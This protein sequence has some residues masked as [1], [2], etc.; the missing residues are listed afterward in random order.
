[1]KGS[2][3]D[4]I[5]NNV[6]S[7]TPREWGSV[8]VRTE[9]GTRDFPSIRHKSYHF[10][11]LAQCH[12]QYMATL[13]CLYGYANTRAKC[14]NIS[15]KQDA[16]ISVY[17]SFQSALHVSGVDYVHLQEHPTV[18]TASGMIHRR[19][20]RPVTGVRLIFSQALFMSSPTFKFSKTE[21]LFEILM[22]KC[23]LTSSSL[24]FLRLY[25]STLNFSAAR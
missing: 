9:T 1:M 23:F 17:S 11:Q 21:T 8:G 2:G 19:C 13:A 3:R 20:C 6:P 15:N 14:N 16:N 22:W 7:S 10:S 12:I 25:L 24:S 5:Y 18:F 4:P